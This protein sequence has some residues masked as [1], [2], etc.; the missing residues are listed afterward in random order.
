MC[1]YIYIYIYLEGWVRRGAVQTAAPRAR[2]SPAPGL[3]PRHG[4]NFRRGDLISVCL[5]SYLFYLYLSYLSLSLYI[6]IYIYVLSLHRH[7]E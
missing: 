4:G 1:V 6:Y 3:K 7:P 5:Y 2:A